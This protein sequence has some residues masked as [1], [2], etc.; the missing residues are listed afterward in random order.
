MQAQSSDSVDFRQLE[1]NALLEITQAI[2]NN[3]SEE[4]LYKIFHFTLRSNLI[5]RKLA[6]FVFET[7][8]ECK[9]YFGLDHPINNINLDILN[10][11]TRKSWILDKGQ[12]GEVVDEFDVL[13]PIAH[14]NKT[15][16][17]IFADGD[18]TFGELAKKEK[19]SFIETIGNILMVA[20]E[21]KRFGRKQL[22]Q[23]ALRREL[24][25]AA[26]VQSMLFPK[27]LP[28]TNE[29]EFAATYIPHHSIGGDYYDYIKVDK[30]KFFVC[31][32]DVSGKGVPAAIYMS[33]FQATLRALVYQGLSLLN[34]VEQLNHLTRVNTGGDYFVTFF[35]ALV[36]IPTKSI[37]YVNAGHNSPVLISNGNIEF[38]EIGTTILGALD[39][40]P[41]IN[42]GSLS[43]TNNSLLFMYTDGM[44]E[45]ENKYEESFEIDR[46]T[47]FL[48]QNKDLSLKDQH[49]GL[50]TELDNFKGS[51]M[52]YK[53][54]I[55]LFSCLL[56]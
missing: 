49:I 13:I 16:A 20:I 12:F 36:D 10:N 14:K 8:W 55:T 48:I 30:N 22:E 7:S 26:E 19:F 46:I 52:R 56:K 47:Q 1:L 35:I 33:N 25:I 43:F 31:I 15:L 6:L 11:E 53:D 37:Q 34:I 39:K 9:T 24:E 54:D 42:I 44:S 5:I 17:Y 38:L 40:L 23:E 32:G 18:E 28:V 41:F 29:F 21:N 2:N 4:S 27:K 3:L 45:T 51:E 50:I